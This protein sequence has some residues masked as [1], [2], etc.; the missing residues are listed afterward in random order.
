[1]QKQMKVKKVLMNTKNQTLIFLN[2]EILLLIIRSNDEFL[3][4][5]FLKI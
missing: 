5:K 2:L 1:M 4:I 3:K